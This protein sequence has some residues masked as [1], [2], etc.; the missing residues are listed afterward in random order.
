MSVLV[1]GSS[2]TLGTRIMRVL[3]SS[4]QP[5]RGF[6]R[7]VGPF[8]TTVADLGDDAALA[9]ALD[10]TTVVIHT[11]AL[12]A[13]DLA[14]A[15]EA[16]FERV[17]V[18]ATARLLRL[19]QHAGVE[20]FVFTSSTSVFGHALEPQGAAVWVTEQ[21]APRPRDAY[22][23]TKLAAE[24]LVREATTRF[25]R[26]AAVLRLARC[27]RE[28]PALR[29]AY[30]LYRGVSLSDAA[31]AH[32]VAAEGV[33]SA[34]A[35]VTARTPFR[36]EDAR[37]LYEDAPAVIAQRCP[38]IIGRFARCGW[39]LPQRVDRVYDGAAAG[40][41]WGF[42]S[43]HDFVGWKPGGSAYDGARSVDDAG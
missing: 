13:P 8:T 27:F 30:R 15:S 28:A 2:G 3:R 22:D 41:A 29:A 24:G 17:N 14:H 38:A 5:A 26:G 6:D 16:A 35:I 43:R 23:R 11:A 12:H 42:Q 25:G 39:A 7:V 20:R 34:L 19:S 10:G 36:P 32:V 9:R 37:T 1:T 21:L 18:L 4:D 40:T 31:R 33:G